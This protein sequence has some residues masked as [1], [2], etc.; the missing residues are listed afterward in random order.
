MLHLRDASVSVFLPISSPLTSINYATSHLL[1]KKSWNVY[2]TDNIARVRRD[3]AAARAREE[4][5]EQRMQERDAE[6]RLAILRGEIP[7]PLEHEAGTA[8]PLFSEHH[9][10]GPGRRDSARRKRKRQG[11]DDTDFEMR[12]AKEQADS[13]GQ[14]PREVLTGSISKAPTSLVDYRGHISLF[15]EADAQRGEK[16]EEAEREATRKKREMED[17]YRMRFSNAAGKEGLGVGVPGPWYTTANGE[18]SGALVPSRDVWG[19]ED[20]GRRV[21]EAVRLDASDPLAMMK[22]GAAQVRELNRERNRE[23]AEREREL[24]EMRREEKRRPKRRRRDEQEQGHTRDRGRSSERRHR[25]E[26]SGRREHSHHDRGRFG[27]RDGSCDDARRHR[28]DD[29]RHRAREHVSV[30]N[31]V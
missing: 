29:S 25:S 26:R 6:R 30:K 13:N 3:E 17:Q 24:N 5:D 27:H 31:T 20:P 9:G 12:M 11:E 23:A 16:N 28:D 10:D 15:S 14:G 21:R 18:P 8:S 19:N 7:P 22:R 1:G 2:N 4:A